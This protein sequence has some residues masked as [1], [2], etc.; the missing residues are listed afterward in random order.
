M[1]LRP[2]LQAAAAPGKSPPSTQASGFARWSDGTLFSI[3]ISISV[4][5]YCNSLG[6]G[7]VYDDTTQILDNPYIVSFHYLRRIF[8]TAA[9]SYVGSYGYTNYYRPVM[10][11]GYLLCFQVFGAAPYGF[12]LANILLHAAVVC[13]LYALTRRMFGSRS[14]AF[15][16]AGIFALHPIHTE[17]VDWVAAVTDP[18]VTLFFLLTFWFFLRLPKPGGKRSEGSVLGMAGSFVLALCSKEQALMLPILA[19]I[20]EHYYRE[21]RRETKWLEKVS[22]Y[23]LLWFLALAYVLF[24]EHMFGAFAPIIGHADVTRYEVCLS[25]IALLGQYVW[26]L[27][28]PASLCAFYVF[29]ASANLLDPR[30][31]EGVAALA[32]GAGGLVFLWQ[33]YRAASF[34]GVWFLATLAPVLDIRVL[35]SDNV[36]A[37]RY[38]YLPSVGFCWLAAFGL[39]KLWD[40]ISV[41]PRAWRWAAGFFLCALAVMCAARIV[42]RNRDWRDEIVFYSTTLQASPEAV[43]IYNYLG[44]VYWNRG[45]WGSAERQWQKALQIVPDSPP[46][47]NN[48]GLLYMKRDELPKAVDYFRKSVAGNPAFPDPHLNLGVAYEQMG[49]KNGAEFQ[50]KVAERL[51]PLNLHIHNRLGGLYLGE[52][53][54]EEAEKQFS[55]SV[56]IAPNV[57]AYDALGEILAQR[58]APAAAEIMFGRS[59]SLNPSDLRARASLAALYRS[60]GRTAQAAE[61]YRTILKF[62]PQNGV[63]QEELRK[64][65]EIGPLNTHG[66]KH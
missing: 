48:L 28:W 49:M 46:L 4:L 41:R 8:T 33:R 54:I 45:D 6:N 56:S 12:H 55:I 3:L 15:L 20:Y 36:F 1:T 32:A 26:K 60:S 57:V 50:Y 40:G 62:D 21:D 59:I 30:V 37:E 24:R 11:F 13:A 23:S 7:F 18:E 65:A 14:V 9:W 58:Q 38:L 34:G 35:A 39:M 51:A 5:P 2:P 17:S 52:G 42:T 10:T 25:G 27:L 29:H 44:S 16:A 31:L 61:Q 64:L 19:T 63:A 43:P 22:R 47:L 53:R 66:A